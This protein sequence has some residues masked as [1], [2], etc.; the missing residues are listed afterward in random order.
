[1]DEAGRGVVVSGYA[2]F[3]S[4]ITTRNVTDNC[5]SYFAVYASDQPMHA[6]LGL[7]EQH[8]IKLNEEI[9]ARR[10]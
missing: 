4:Y 9:G 5:T 1:M 6:T 3:A 10:A 8:R 2:L 7:V